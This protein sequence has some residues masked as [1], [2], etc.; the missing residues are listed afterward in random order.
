VLHIISFLGVIS[1]FFL[2]ASMVTRLS[3]VILLGLTMIISGCNKPAVEAPP[4]SAQKTAPA[5]AFD[6]SSQLNTL[7]SDLS[8]LKEKV[9]LLSNNL[10][11]MSKDFAKL[12]ASPELNLTDQVKKLDADF[13]IL[14]DKVD[15]MSNNLASI[16]KDLSSVSNKIDS[17]SNNYAGLASQM[18]ALEPNNALLSTESEGYTIANTKFGPFIIM[19]RGVSPY[20]EGFKVK[21][22]I[23]NLTPAAFKGARLH[24]TLGNQ[25]NKIYNISDELSPQAYTNVEIAITPAKADEIKALQVGLE[26]SQIYLKTK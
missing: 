23:G 26:L 20:Q 22:G 15:S 3:A 7:N 11:S 8:T 21:L 25:Q 6:P 4:A 17:I 14:K 10:D 16:S 9:D 13:P 1:I 2:E 19:K 5:P 24:V 18:A 12:K